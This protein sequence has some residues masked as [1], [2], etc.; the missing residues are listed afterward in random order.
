[1]QQ[2]GHHHTSSGVWERDLCTEEGGKDLPERTEMRK[3]RWIIGLSHINNVL[4]YF[5]KELLLAMHCS[6][7]Q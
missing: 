2:Q 1:M 5:I 3:L 4:L 6:F 7:P